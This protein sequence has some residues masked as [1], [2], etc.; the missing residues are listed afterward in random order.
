M[1][2]KHA[3]LINLTLTPLILQSI[4]F[5]MKLFRTTDMGAIRFCQSAFNFVLPSVHIAK[6][7]DACKKI[8]NRPNVMICRLLCA[9]H[10]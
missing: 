5:F 4:G 10:R 3:L 7:R 6:R 1:A 8:Q 9:L 2:Q